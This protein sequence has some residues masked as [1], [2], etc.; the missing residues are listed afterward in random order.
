MQLFWKLTIGIALIIGAGDVVSR[1]NALPLRA[2]DVIL[3]GE[4]IKRAVCEGGMKDANGTYTQC[5]VFPVDSK[6]K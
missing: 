5:F 3:T 4:Q 2:P 6:L 1:L